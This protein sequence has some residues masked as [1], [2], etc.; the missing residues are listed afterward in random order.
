MRPIDTR[1]KLVDVGVSSDLA[2]E[3]EQGWISRHHGQAMELVEEFHHPTTIDEGQL[4]NVV[5]QFASIMFDPPRR[6]SS[7]ESTSN[8]TW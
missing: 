2:F 5:D 7:A 1:Q 8:A 4:G 3:F 6:T